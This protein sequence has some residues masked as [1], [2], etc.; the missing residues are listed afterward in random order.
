MFE[1]IIYILYLNNF[2]RICV[3]ISKFAS[4]FNKKY[5]YRITFFNY[6]KKKRKKIKKNILKIVYQPKIFIFSSKSNRN[7]IIKKINSYENLNLKNEFSYHGHKNVYQSE[8]N[9]NKN[10]K[11]KKISRKLEKSVNLKISKYLN[12]KKLSLIRMWFVITK[13]SGLIKKHSHLNSDFSA[14]Y[15]LK[16]DKSKSNTSGIKI[17]NDLGKIEI[18]KF[19]EKKKK[20][21]IKVLKKKYLLFKPK[22]NDLII[23]N[24]YIEHSVNNHGSKIVNRISL[25]FDLSLN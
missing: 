3:Y 11:F 24:S 1:K 9:L 19:N 21:L 7:H 20:F 22:N 8:H 5:N 6:F 10:I 2:F 15:Y 12:F 4:I 17:Y 13:K 25:P 23:F 18:Y 14:V 16:V